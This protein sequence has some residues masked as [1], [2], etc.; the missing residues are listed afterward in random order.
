M[1][2]LTFAQRSEAAK[3]GWKTRRANKLRMGEISAEKYFDIYKE[4][5]TG[6]TL[7]DEY[8]NEY[9]FDEYEDADEY[10]Y[11]DDYT[12]LGELIDKRITLTLEKCVTGAQMSQYILQ[13]LD[14]LKAQDKTEYYNNLIKYQDEIDTH[15]APFERDYDIGMMYD[16]G[17]KILDYASGVSGYGAMYEASFKDARRNDAFNQYHRKYPNAKYGKRRKSY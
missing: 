15:L 7:N 11:G 3:K 8:G 4:L 14:N 13:I 10:D 6:Y 12:N 1:A 9:E 2:K 16:S 5:P 17:I